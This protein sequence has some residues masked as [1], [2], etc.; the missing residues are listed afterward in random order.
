[1]SDTKPTRK[2]VPCIEQMQQTECGLCCMAMMM[3]YYKSHVSLYELR[4]RM[5]NGRDGTTL[6]HLKKLAEQL[7]FETKPYK[8]ETEQLKQMK[9]PAIIF[10]GED[11]FV[12]LEKIKKDREFHIVDPGGGRRK[13]TRDDFDK[14]F[15]GYILTLYPGDRFEYKKEKNVWWSFVPFIT[16]RPKLFGTILMLTLL[17]QLFTVG[18]PMLIQFVVDHIIVPM[19]VSILHVFLIGI[20]GVVLFHMLFTYIRG[21]TLITFH[22]AIDY[23]MQTKFFSHILKLPYQFFLLRSFG[24][25]IFRA[26]SMK[27]IRDQLTTQV[28]KGIL[29]TAVLVV[30]L[31]Y[32]A[33]QSWLM[34]VFVLVIAALNIALISLSKRYISETNQQ[35]ILNHAKVQGTQTE[36]L[37]GIFGVKTSGVEHMMYRR[38]LERFNSLLSSYRKKETILNYVNTASSSLQLL[39][40]L[41]ILWIG[42]Y[43]VFS[44]QITL[45]VLIAFHAISGQFF[46]LSG[47]V[48]NM[49]QAFIL[50]TSYLKRVEDVLEAPAELGSMEEEP[51]YEPVRGNIRLENVSFSFSKYSERVVDDLSMTISEGQKVALVGQSGSGKTTI[52]NLIIGIFKPVSGTI[53]YDGKDLEDID[54]QQLRRRIGTVPQDV[55]LFNRSIYENITLHH[56]DATPEEVVEAAKVSQIHDEIMAMPMQYNT[57]V[58]EMG[59]NLSGGQRQRIALAKALL[60]KPSILVLDEATSS[61]DHVNEKKIDDYLSSI[62]CTRIVIAHRLTTVMNSDMICVVDKGKIMEYGTHKDLLHTGGFYSH[63][64]KNLS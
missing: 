35:E 8:A 48:V 43:Q 29:D 61:L 49:V 25:L 37:Y 5:G 33:Y 47:S 52:A 14:K 60:S 19:E 13:L 17:L 38:W 30:I 3:G 58:S 4:E 45:G 9:L 10:W 51:D 41:I 46:N 40:P 26:N 6:F 2:R 23:D 56:P 21:R 32:M 55:T 16:N 18:M 62:N 22:N 24:D 57:M 34:T 44:G 31:L 7:G 39:A 59:M 28:V 64:Y 36:M 11:H 15:T 53:Y 20:L 63:F 1:M 54:L 27:V 50:T 42:A 12:V